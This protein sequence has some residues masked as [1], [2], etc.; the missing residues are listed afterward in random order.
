M[1]LVNIIF[2]ICFL[3]NALKS[4]C[5]TESELG[6]L[7]FTDILEE[8]VENTGDEV[9]CSTESKVCISPDDIK[10]QIENNLTRCKDKRNA[11]NKKK[12]ER[13]S[14]DGMKIKNLAEGLTKKE[15]GQRNKSYPH[16]PGKNAD[17]KVEKIKEKCTESECQDLEKKITDATDYKECFETIATVMAG[18]YCG[19]I[20][21]NGSD[22]AKIDST[23]YI[24]GINVTE[25]SAIQVFEKCITYF[26]SQ[27]AIT[28]IY[29]LSEEVATGNASVKKGKGKRIQEACEN[30]SE[31]DVCLD[32]PTKCNTELKVE[33]LSS[34]ISIGKNCSPGED[35]EDL[36]NGSK[37]LNALYEVPSSSSSRL[38]EAFKAR[39]LE[40]AI[41]SCDI[42]V[43]ADGY[44]AYKAG[45][46]SGIDFSDYTESTS[47][48]LSW[49]F[50]S[51]ISF[52]A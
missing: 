23:G 5:L 16:N 43:D 48:L 10:K 28:N 18:A 4:A 26:Q 6:S 19:L 22:Y 34:F 20:G 30:V 29:K 51:I 8:A 11:Q 15:N 9:T 44:D 25:E 32:D 31:I 13:I 40:E 35:D 50:V 17:I 38:L 49:L 33:F 47:I 1:K 24:I 3:A 45:T 21:E 42:S 46:D 7:G 14:E 52:I 2:T 37:T 41:T 12:G 27:C 36:D 39:I